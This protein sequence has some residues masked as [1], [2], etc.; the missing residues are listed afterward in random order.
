MQLGRSKSR[1]KAMNIWRVAIPNF[2]TCTSTST[3]LGCFERKSWKNMEKS[4][5]EIVISTVGWIGQPG[6]PPPQQHPLPVDSRRFFDWQVL[7]VLVSIEDCQAARYSPQKNWVHLRTPL[8]VKVDLY[9][10]G[11]PSLGTP[12]LHGI[13][14]AQCLCAGESMKCPSLEVF[15]P[16]PKQSRSCSSSSSPSSSSSSSSSS[17]STALP[18]TATSQVTSPKVWDQ[19]LQLQSLGEYR[20]MARQLLAQSEFS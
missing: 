19:F 3:T 15:P 8:G 5:R 4:Y 9:P 11:C 1:I 14:Q 10:H 16:P 2:H 12:E 13:W 18:R 6:Q 20:R 17:A 7:G